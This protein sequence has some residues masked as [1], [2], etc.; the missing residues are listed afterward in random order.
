MK[1]YLLVLIFISINIHAKSQRSTY[2]DALYLDQ[3]LKSSVQKKILLSK[4]V[5]QLLSAYYLSSDTFSINRNLLD[6]NPFFKDLFLDQAANSAGKNFIGNS[7]S[8]VGGLDVTNFADGMAKFIVKRTKQELSIAFFERFKKDLDSL[9]QFQILFPA[10]FN[11][12]NAIDKDIY[13]FSA[14]LD[15]FHD[16]FQKDLALLLPNIDKLIKDKCMDIVFVKYP[17]IRIMLSDAIYI[18]NEFSEGKHPGDV[19]HNYITLQADSNSLNKIEPNLYPSLRV[20]DLVSRSLR[21]KQSA[22]FWV[23][24]DSLKLLLDDTTFNIYLGLIY[25][26]AS[27]SPIKFS[28][29][30]FTEI[31]KTSINNTKPYKDYLTGLI[32]KGGNANYYFKAIKEKQLTGKDKP[33]YQ[34]YYSLYDATLTVLEHLVQFPPLSKSYDLTR[35]NEYFNTARSLGNIYVDIYEKQYSTAIVEFSSTYSNLMLTK[36]GYEI[37]FVSD[38]IDSVKNKIGAETDALKKKRL[39]V[40]KKALEQELIKLK[41]IQ[42]TSSI[43]LKYGTFAATVAKAENSD[44]VQN[45]I[46]SIALPAGSSR[47]KRESKT[48]ISINAYCGFFGGRNFGSK[49]AYN[50]FGITAPVGIATSFG[51]KHSSLSAFVSLIDFGAITAFRFKNDTTTVS[52]ILLKDIVSPGLFL[53]WGLPNCPISINA[54]CQLTPLISSVSSSGNSTEARMFRFTVGLC[55]DIPVLNLY[56]RSK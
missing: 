51:I 13:N 33:T 20:F 12:F 26:Q 3:K 53:S 37:K 39:E 28:N 50:S 45:A 7:I 14:Y 23:S 8:S 49:S 41:G 18:A 1:K 21:S 9:K 17:E 35:V 5:L 38:R 6:K 32:S 31:L 48:N 54:G 56:N 42:E 10:T 43:I 27:Q 19:I 40:E 11:A 47:V 34:D 29:K 4:D 15:L 52:K 30:S 25:Q 46:E 24:P 36:V 44:D 2:Y 16:S 22:Q 55:V